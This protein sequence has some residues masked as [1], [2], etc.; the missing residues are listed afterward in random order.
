M[1]NNLIKLSVFFDVPVWKERAVYLLS[2]ILSSAKRYPISFGAWSL[3][4]Q[5]ITYGLK[6]IVIVGKDHV[7]L[8]RKVVN[9]YIPLKIIQASAK[10]DEDW[11]LLREKIIPSNQTKIYICENY[12]CLKP[13]ESFEEFKD[14]LTKHF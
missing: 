6:E 3:N 14:Q 4:I 2:Y 10:E 1:T 9:E 7:D 11:P 13:A 5:L 12:S 8:L